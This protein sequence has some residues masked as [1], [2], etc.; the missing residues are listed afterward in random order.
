VTRSVPQPQIS[1]RTPSKREFIYAERSM[2]NEKAAGSDN[3]PP[4]IWQRERFSK[5]WK[6]GIVI[7][8]PKKI[9]LSLCNN[10]RGITLLVVISKMF[11]KIILERIIC[12]LENNLRKEQ[13]GFC[14][15][16]SCIDQINT[17]R[18]IIER[19]VE[20]QSPLYMMFVDYNFNL[21]QASSFLDETNSLDSKQ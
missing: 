2:K 21:K 10:W 11:N 12:A 7:K 3:I 18:T 6:E 4:E 8:I 13:A 19:S 17:L 20:F 16:T 15:N 1:V 9:D 14:P 5:E